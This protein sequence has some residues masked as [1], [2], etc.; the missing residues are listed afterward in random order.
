LALL[1]SC[2]HQV[3]QVFFDKAERSLEIGVVELVGHTPAQRT[4]FSSFD[5]NG[6]QVANSE[7]KVLPV[8]VIDFFQELLV[9]HSGKGLVE[10]GFET[11]RRLIGDLDH[12]LQQTK[13]ESIVRLA[14]N[15]KSEVLVRL[16]CV[17]VVERNDELFGFLHELQT[18]LTILK[19]DPSTGFHACLY[20]LSCGFLLALTHGHLFS[21]FLFL[22]GE[23]VDGASGI[24][25]RR[26]QEQDRNIVL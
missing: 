8:G 3:V 5:D 13:R 18:E 17:W 22:P 24:G 2:A 1:G 9:D 12:F 25:T 21:Y 26:K 23:V 7:D 6:V 14:S 10:T 11:L 4:E 20:G 19:N 16:D 15:P